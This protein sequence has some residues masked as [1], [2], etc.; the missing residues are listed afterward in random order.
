M[1]KIIKNNKLFKIQSKAKQSSLSYL[2]LFNR[3]KRSLKSFVIIWWII[4]TTF[5]PVDNSWIS[6]S[7][8][9]ELMFSPCAPSSFHLKI[10]AGEDRYIC[11]SLIYPCIIFIYCLLNY[12]VMCCQFL[13]FLIYKQLFSNHLMQEIHFH[14][15][16]VL[17]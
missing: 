16:L 8:S 11:M 13:C 17:S 2:K 7:L 12:F 1:Y 9:G 5:S 14:L 15:L 6:R 10:I 4:K 3:R